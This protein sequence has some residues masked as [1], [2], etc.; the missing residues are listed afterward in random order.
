VRE[1]IERHSSDS[2]AGPERG[3]PDDL[4]HKIGKGH[5]GIRGHSKQTPIGSD[6]GD[7]TPPGRVCSQVYRILRD[8]ALARAIKTLYNHECQPCGE[9]ILLPSGERYSEAHHIH[10]L[11]TPHNG[12]DVS[13]NILVL[14]PKHHVMC[15]Y[16]VIRCTRASLRL[17]AEHD[18]LEHFLAYHNK[19]V[20]LAAA[21]DVGGRDGT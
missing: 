8:T 4:F 17:H 2:E 15:D 9:T 7:V 13:G 10:P 11:G 1:R 20:E 21:A 6:V 12:P 16:F 18:V 5:W 3:S 14:C 19:N